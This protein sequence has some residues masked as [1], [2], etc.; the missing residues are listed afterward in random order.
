MFPF[1]TILT[2]YGNNVF[3]ALPNICDWISSSTSIILI[4]CR[5]IYCCN[6]Q[7]TKYKG[8]GVHLVISFFFWVLCL[9]CFDITKEITKLCVLTNS[10]YITQDCLVVYIKNIILTYELVLINFLIMMLN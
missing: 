9:T 7:P 1:P 10:E 2:Y 8:S 5:S 3:L 4:L 6:A